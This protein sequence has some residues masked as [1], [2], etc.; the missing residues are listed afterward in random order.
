MA[1]LLNFESSTRYH[2]GEVPL[3]GV[4]MSSEDRHVYFRSATSA[5]FVLALEAWS[6]IQCYHLKCEHENCIMGYCRDSH[7]KWHRIA[8]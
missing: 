1:S 8:H 7:V 6:R 4:D 5:V 2:A 3:M